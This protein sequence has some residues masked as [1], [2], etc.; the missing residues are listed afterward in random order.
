MATLVSAPM[1]QVADAIVHKCGL[2]SAVLSGIVPD[3]RHLGNGGYHCSI[4]DLRAYGNA[5]D[6]SNTR[7]DDK[8]LN[9]RYGAAFDVTMNKA[10]MIRVYRRVHA[11]WRDKTDP[12]R[13]YVNCLNV[14]D[15][16]GD[17]V[18]LDFFTGQAKYASPDHK[19]HVH[20]EFRRRWVNDPKAARAIASMFKGESKAT[21][22]AREEGA[23]AAPPVKTAPKPIA[24]PVTRHAP[25]SR[26]L[27]YVPGKT[28]MSGDDVAYVQRFLGQQKAGTP[29]GDFGA[30]TRAAVVWYQRMR[31]LKADGIVG[32][33][34][35][36]SMGIKNSL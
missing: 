18:R 28:I 22:N 27:Q 3:R 20:G 9:V 14:W 30:K 24:K 11:V 26:V 4:E 35:W 17:A 25:G 29:D 34:T 1:R 23:K 7:A 5:R 33:A 36:R 6:Y 15:G 32:A 16:S 8:N 21:W 13:K 31:G 19:W 12:R 2:K 10:D